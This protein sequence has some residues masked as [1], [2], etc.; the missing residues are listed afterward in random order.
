MK[1]ILNYQFKN[2]KT[3]VFNDLH[4]KGVKH[5]LPFDITN[6]KKENW[7]ENS[8]NVNFINS[9]SLIDQLKKNIIVSQVG[10]KVILL[11]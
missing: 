5:D 10:K 2:N 9:Y 8:Y 11:I 7:I 6:I 1:I 4:T 3:Y